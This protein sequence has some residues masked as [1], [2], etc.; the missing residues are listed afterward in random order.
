MRKRIIVFILC[1]SFMAGLGFADGF[2]APSVYSGPVYRLHNDYNTFDLHNIA[3]GIYS[4]FNLRLIRIFDLTFDLVVPGIS[5][6]PLESMFDVIKS[7][8]R[9]VP[10]VYPSE[11]FRELV[12]A[13][14]IKQISISDLLSLGGTS[15]SEGNIRRVNLLLDWVQEMLQDFD[16]VLGMPFGWKG[17]LQIRYMNIGIDVGQEFVEKVAHKVAVFVT[18]GVDKGITGIENVFS[19]RKSKLQKTD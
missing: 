17:L 5:L 13:F 6:H 16:S 14:R 8:Y 10:R 18:K 19:G 9:A 2:N 7:G 3:S 11:K 15:L 1:I 12:E 4:V